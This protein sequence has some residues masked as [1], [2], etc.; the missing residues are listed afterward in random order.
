MKQHESTRRRE[1]TS[2]SAPMLFDHA[3]RAVR[4]DLDVCTRRFDP[5]MVTVTEGAPAL[6]KN[7]PSVQMRIQRDRVRDQEPWRLFQGPSGS[8]CRK[9]C[10]ENDLA[11]RCVESP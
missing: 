2:L 11:A 6:Q 9:E 7:P 8:G 1:L 10:L 3:N 4:E 5:G